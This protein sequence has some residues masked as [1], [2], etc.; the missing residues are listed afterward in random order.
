MAAKKVKFKLQGHEKFALREGWIN[1]ALITIPDVPG[2]FLRKDATDI[3]GIG[4]NMVKSLRYWLRAFGLTI[5]KSS[6]GVELTE[7]GK[8]IAKYDPYLE[9]LFTLW[10]MHSYISKNKEDATTWFMYFNHCDA[11]DLKK[12]EIEV[13]LLRELKK[14]IAGQNF[15]EKSLSNDVDVLL[16]MYSKNKEK[17]DPEDK[18][19]SPFSHLALIKNIGGTYT[20][21]HPNKK[22]F[23]EM[24][25]LYELALMSKDL[26]GVS[27][28]KAVHGENGLANIY[29][30]TSVMANDYFDKLDDAGYIHVNRTA[31]LDM[32]YFVQKKE[33]L[34]VLEEYYKNR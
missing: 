25:V 20:K 12:N 24:I 5:E 10:I 1:K 28:E 2:V 21:S 3:F 16:N 17:S 6:A 13:I 15:S 22:D 19:I 23:S 30:L 14:Y 7:R 29:N 11:D 27:I 9:D 8:L 31:G 26:E 33:E 32:I 4:S 34:D 18:N